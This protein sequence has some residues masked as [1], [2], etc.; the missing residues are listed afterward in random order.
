MSLSLLPHERER[1]VIQV[2]LQCRKGIRALEIRIIIQTAPADVR[3]IDPCLDHVFAAG[4]GEN[5]VEGYV[6]L[7]LQSVP[8]RAASGEGIEHHDFGSLLQTHCWRVLPPKHD[9]ELVQ[10]PFGDQTS[11]IEKE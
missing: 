11:V 3:N 9:S 5:L 1:P 7:S 4:P 6:I 8:L 10:K 2:I